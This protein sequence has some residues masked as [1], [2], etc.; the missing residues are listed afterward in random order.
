MTPCLCGG[1]PRRIRTRRR[2]GRTAF[3]VECAAC[4]KRTHWHRPN[5]GDLHE[6][7]TMNA[8]KGAA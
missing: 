7:E 8:R 1:E 6:W 3:A 2:G 5:G 4:G